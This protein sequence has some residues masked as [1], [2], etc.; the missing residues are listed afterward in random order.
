[1]P[2]DQLDDGSARVIQIPGVMDVLSMPGIENEAIKR[3]RLTRWR[4]NA[5]RT[6][7]PEPLRWLPQVINW[8]DDAQD[9]LIT[10]LV[11]G[12]PLLRKL[13]SR[14]IPYL[15]YGLLANDALNLFTG[16]LSAPLNPRAAKVDFLRTTRNAMGGRT[17]AVRAGEAFLLPG[18]AKFIPFALQAGQ[19]LYSFTGWGLKLGPIMATV[20]ESFWG[21]LNTLR[22]EKV[23]VLGPPPSDPLAKAARVL[24]RS[25]YWNAFAQI[26]NATEQA[27]MT[28]AQNVGMGFLGAPRLI[29]VLD[30][31]L[32]VLGD[33]SLPLFRPGSQITDRILTLAGYPD[34]HD[35]RQPVPT[36]A[37]HPRI[38]TAVAASIAAEP[39]TDLQCAL[40]WRDD[41]QDWPMG[42]MQTELAQT[43]WDAFGYGFNTVVPLNS[44]MERALGL[45][46]EH[47]V[48]P[49][50]L[51]LPN[52]PDV[53]A[54]L[55]LGTGT[56]NDGVMAWPIDVPNKRWIHDWRAPIAYP[57][58][59]DNPHVQLAWW[60]AIM[61]AI[62]CRRKLLIPQTGIDMGNGHWVI[63]GWGPY[64]KA[65]WPVA[66][67]AS[68]LVW[69]NVYVR[70]TA[71]NQDT[72]GIEGWR[73][74][75]C[76]L[77]ADGRATL[78][79][80]RPEY[81]PFQEILDR[82]PPPGQPG[83]PTPF[84]NQ[85]LGPFLDRDWLLAWLRAED[86][87]RAAGP[88][89]PPAGDQVRPVGNV[90]LPLD[91]DRWDASKGAPFYWLE[92][93]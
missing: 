69:G 24:V 22:G 13:P 10:A 45:A 30:D 80:V 52:P 44:P 81:E 20:S 19:V 90:P 23:I 92:R 60:C 65:Q 32:D 93:I 50:F 25:P 2:P 83:R 43:T 53:R 21:F 35:Q 48:V 27:I 7:I 85:G 34:V 1:M 31:R 3:E 78:S 18:R 41:F 71:A 29:E 64:A 84:D 47:G 74:S 67:H 38:A 79:G 87:R 57:P 51:A 68:I 4:V 9:L 72:E 77:T 37:P 66:A 70:T 56:A 14:F 88:D 8:L 28:A 63:T 15:G 73:P 49:P 46:L 55:H 12:L 39:D 33:L 42:M 6:N 17:A 54:Q 91:Q 16:M 61:L 75:F 89:F 5:E 58:P 40:T 11:A 26:A 76:V 62:I 59:S 36:E 86:A 82:L